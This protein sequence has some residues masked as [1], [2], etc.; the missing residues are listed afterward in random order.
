MI[1]IFNF[2]LFEFL[3]LTASTIGEEK[4][5]NRRLTKSKEEFIEIMKKL[6]LSKPKYIGNSLIPSSFS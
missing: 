5:C 6:N 4:K 3:G 2:I 1:N